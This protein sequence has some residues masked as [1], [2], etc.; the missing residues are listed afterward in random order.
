MTDRKMIDGLAYE[1]AEKKT[2]LFSSIDSIGGWPVGYKYVGFVHSEKRDVGFTNSSRNDG[3][4][5]V[6]ATSDDYYFWKIS[7][8]GKQKIRD[9]VLT[10]TYPV[11]PKAE[12]IFNGVTTL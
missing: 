2:N 5:T 7:D 1:F 8:G 12:I 10:E 4:W 3:W 6:V 11:A 9:R